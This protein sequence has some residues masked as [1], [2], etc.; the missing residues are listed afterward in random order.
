MKHFEFR[1][2]NI[3]NHGTRDGWEK[4]SMFDSKKHLC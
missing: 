1:T 4:R 2:K 3:H